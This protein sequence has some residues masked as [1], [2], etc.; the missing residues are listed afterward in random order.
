MP[1]NQATN[2]LLNL[3]L[4]EGEIIES[5][6]KSSEVN[7]ANTLFSRNHFAGKERNGSTP[8]RSLSKPENSFSPNTQ[9][10]QPN[11][12]HEKRQKYSTSNAP[13]R[14]SEPNTVWHESTADVPKRDLECSDT[15]NF[16]SQRQAPRMN[17]QVN[18]NWFVPPMTQAQNYYPEFQ[19][20]QAF[21]SGNVFPNSLQNQFDSTAFSQTPYS[22]TPFFPPPFNQQSFNQPL[23]QFTDL[24]NVALLPA[25][26]QIQA[27]QNNSEQLLEIRRTLQAMLLCGV[28]VQNLTT[29][30]LS[31]EF[32]AFCMGSI[33]INPN[34]P[35]HDT[36]VRSHIEI[37]EMTPEKAVTQN[38]LTA[39]VNVMA[40]LQ[41]DGETEPANNFEN[42]S[43]IEENISDSVEVRPQSVESSGDYKD[44][45]IDSEEQSDEAQ[46]FLE[47]QLENLNKPYTNGQSNSS[48][49]TKYSTSVHVNP[50][51]RHRPSAADLNNRAI[52]QS[53]HDRTAK[54]FNDF[55][56]YYIELSDSSE[57][58]EEAEIRKSS[59]KNLSRSTIPIYDANIVQMKML[60]VEIEKKELL[61]QIELKKRKA[62]QIQSVLEGT[63]P[64]VAQS[65]LPNENE[66][67][68]S[69]TSANIIES[70]KS[71][72]KSE[73]DTY[74][75]ELLN[76]I[77]THET[78]IK[79][80]ETQQNA[81]ENSLKD[82]KTDHENL[83]IAIE[84]DHK[85]LRS[86]FSE[87]KSL[88]EELI[89]KK[90]NLK[91]TEARLNSTKEEIQASNQKMLQARN[92][93]EEIKRKFS[94]TLQELKQIEI[95]EQQILAELNDSKRKR[96]KLDETDPNDSDF[97]M[98]PRDDNETDPVVS[99]PADDFEDK[100]SNWF[101][102]IN[103]M[104]STTIPM[105]SFCGFVTIEQDISFGS[106]L[107]TKAF[108]TFAGDVEKSET[109]E[110]L[111]ENG[112]LSVT[113]LTPYE[114]F[115][116]RFKSYRLNPAYSDN[117]KS[118][119]R[120]LTYSEEIITDL[121]TYTTSGAKRGKFAED[122]RP[123]GQP[124]V[125]ALERTGHLIA[126]QK[127]KANSEFTPL[128]K[129]ELS[130][131][132]RK[133][134]IQSVPVT[135]TVKF[136]EHN[137]I[138]PSRQPILVNGLIKMIEG[139]SQIT[140]KYTRYYQGPTTEEEYLQLLSR[141]SKNEGLWLNF[142][143][144]AIPQQLSHE[145]L[146]KI[147]GNLN[148]AIKI[149]ARALQSNRESE[150]LWDLYLEIYSR[151]GTESD[152]REVF[153]QAVKYVPSCV[154][155]WW[156]HYLWEKT[157]DAK[158]KLLMTM[159]ERSIIFNQLEPEIRS[160]HLLNA[161]VQRATLYLDASEPDLAISWLHHFFTQH[162]V[163]DIIN[164]SETPKT[165]FEVL[166]S[167]HQLTRS[168]VNSVLTKKD[169]ALGWLL[170]FTIS[171]Y[172]RIPFSTLNEAPND[173][174]VRNEL[175]VI[176]WN[177]DRSTMWCDLTYTDQEEAALLQAIEKKMKSV[178]TSWRLLVKPENKAP[179]LA[180]LHSYVM[181]VKKIANGS[182]L[183][184]RDLKVFVGKSVQAHPEI[185][186]LHALIASL[187]H[188][189]YEFGNREVGIR[190]MVEF[191]NVEPL[192]FAMWNR[193]AKLYISRGP[194]FEVHLAI[195]LI[196]AIRC[197]FVGREQVQLSK[198][199]FEF[200]V[201]IDDAMVLYHFALGLHIPEIKSHEFISE[202]SRSMLC[203]NLFVWLNY[204]IL[205]LLYQKIKSKS[206]IPTLSEMVFVKNVFEQ[207]VEGMKEVEAKFARCRG[208]EQ[209]L[210]AKDFSADIVSA[211]NL[212]M[213]NLDSL[214]KKH[215]FDYQNRSGTHSEFLKMISIN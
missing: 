55:S 75:N 138:I 81:H 142:C 126:T 148:S 70:T 87:I 5:D 19:Q 159:V 83:V 108:I 33:D 40:P 46:D 123:E 42:Q 176:N 190:N 38:N 112:N 171:Y 95:E 24:A 50:S 147:S 31:F 166:S 28:S 129:K 151:R 32:I 169:L 156:R 203:S 178:L 89:S 163:Q 7:S 116:S 136:L 96:R 68:I 48:F 52:S 84:A 20:S 160:H 115:M 191:L 132:I 103:N 212:G 204:G 67:L 209:Q 2:S 177:C 106:D 44:M 183:M 205:S 149:L 23:S 202:V 86:L 60:K 57:D 73:L 197:C 109:S 185:S 10:I 161:A 97:I 200:E 76:S 189:R 201:I 118:G 143:L 22:Q 173:W 56:K 88:E 14:V 192:N 121:M 15:E 21:Y 90:N 120:S 158:N 181:C 6:N 99:E 12:F 195:V 107:F 175:F 128:L 110:K 77:K 94:G 140:S 16:Y 196:N 85:A 25:H 66:C 213:K 170:F 11:Y 93:M 145:S 102:K 162:S 133:Q 215:P 182:L 199:V 144:N 98:I 146:Y 164:F 27:I 30:G 37:V 214:K 105:F 198:S 62:G 207:S 184:L 131:K 69:S 41:G 130:P 39:D 53:Y 80:L 141:D 92:E 117:V 135:H 13:W 211:L 174:L 100:I 114:S 3:P 179:Y 82:L 187:E 157:I 51:F 168:F 78:Q 18:S 113:K 49:P 17:Q 139:D 34:Q 36:S 165:I 122:T 71:L 43:S 127:W 64:N 4:E 65:P 54:Y 119:F 47:S 8:R 79:E 154:K 124:T 125:D 137:F 193:L 180:L 172:K 167:P 186:E 111:N 72:R 63:I 61:K 104:C 152:V 150:S 153:E 26:L 74:K 188:V 29:L 155:L 194:E 9:N 134:N 1:T 59:S 35:P 210:A 208:Q 101:E 206:D 45:D 91:V 58:E